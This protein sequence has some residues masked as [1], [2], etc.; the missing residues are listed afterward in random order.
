MLTAQ[1][2]AC[3]AVNSE[4]TIIR[5]G[6]IQDFTFFRLAFFES[7]RAYMLTKPSPKKRWMLSLSLILLAALVACSASSTRSLRSSTSTLV[8]P[9]AAMKTVW[10]SQAGSSRSHRY[11]YNAQSGEY[12]GLMRQGVKFKAFTPF[13][14][15]AQW[16]KA[17]DDLAA[18]EDLKGAKPKR[19][20]SAA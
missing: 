14:L 15:G 1:M 20:V 10:L 8:A 19:A 11:G 18:S 4:R 13:G 12:G 6:L 2:I 9:P 7:C 5:W 17:K 16:P 3:P